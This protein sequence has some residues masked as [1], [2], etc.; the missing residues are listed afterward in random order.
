MSAGPYDFMYVRFTKAQN[1]LLRYFVGTSLADVEGKV[2][3]EAQ[4][5]SIKVAY[6]FSLYVSA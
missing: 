1:V 2:L 5:S 4:G 6:P 3:S